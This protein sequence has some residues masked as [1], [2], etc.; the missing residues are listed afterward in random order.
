M[1]AQDAREILDNLGEKDAEL[2]HSM[3]I[4][5]E[6]SGIDDQCTIDYHEYIPHLIN[7]IKDLWSQLVSVKEELRL[8]KEEKHNG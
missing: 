1:I 4:P 2:E 3:Y 7:Y 5:N 6:V 8:L